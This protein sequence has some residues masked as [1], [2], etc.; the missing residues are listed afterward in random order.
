MQMNN[1]RNNLPTLIRLTTL[2][3]MCALTQ[4]SVT[5]STASGNATRDGGPK[6][7]RKTDVSRVAVDDGGGLRESPRDGRRRATPRARETRNNGRSG[8]PDATHKKVTAAPL[9]DD[10]K[11]TN[12]GWKQ[13]FQQ[14]EDE[15]Y[16]CH[17]SIGN[18]AIHLITLST[19]LNIYMRGVS[20]ITHR[21]ECK[22]G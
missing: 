5:V 20:R 21:P 17:V 4:I 1:R 14:P 2:I 11:V 10:S 19:R 22:Y 15:K 7:G 13:C 12:P 6:T 18:I 3:C 16:S 8:N 9:K